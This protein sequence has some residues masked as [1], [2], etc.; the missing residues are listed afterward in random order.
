MKR[1]SFLR[2]A[3]IASAAAGIGGT[4]WKWHEI[5]PGLHAPGREE[6]HFLRDLASHP[7]RLP[8]VTHT[9]QTDVAILG[10]GIG[11]LTAAWK[12]ERSGHHDFLVIDGPEADG[13]AA[14]ALR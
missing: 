11:G 2:T 3:G 14:G 13:N 1:R 9:L 4:W 12:L 6:G 5:Q 8:P 10:S 7:D